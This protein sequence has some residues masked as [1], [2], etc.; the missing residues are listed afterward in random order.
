[1]DCSAWQ[2]RVPAEVFA[3][4]KA[5]HGV[6]EFIP[7]IWG[8]GPQGIGANPYLEDQVRAALEA[9]LRVVR[10]YVWP[11]AAAADAIGYWEITL[12]DVRI[13]RIVLDVEAGTRLTLADVQ[14][15]RINRY[16]PEIYTAYGEWERLMADTPWYAS[17]AISGV[18]LWAA[19]Y[20][21]REWDGA[22]PESL[23]ELLGSRWVPR[24]WQGKPEL[25]V[26]WQ[27]AGT[28]NVAGSAFDLN[29]FRRVNG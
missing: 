23:D 22:W 18:E 25:I 29:I 21:A 12:P 2:G 1:M 3:R 26:G 20:P 13:R 19:W 11:P 16:I 28:V 5:E 8:G 15:V 9:G 10:A 14:R 6:E 27:F 17:F 7:Q 4:L 24:P